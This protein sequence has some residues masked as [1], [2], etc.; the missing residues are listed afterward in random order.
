MEKLRK[1]K[2]E[3]KMFRICKQS[4][5]NSRLMQSTTKKG[6]TYQKKS[7][8]G[9]SQPKKNLAKKQEKSLKQVNGLQNSAK[10]T[11]GEGGNHT[12]SISDSHGTDFGESQ[13]I[14]I[15]A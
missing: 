4:P 10:S 8:F 11:N 12:L 2:K 5:N 9:N 13:M 14:V 3:L 7:E 6:A 15:L 1:M